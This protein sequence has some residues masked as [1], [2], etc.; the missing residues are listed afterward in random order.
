M[1]SSIGGFLL[2]ITGGTYYCFMFVP[3][4]HDTAVHY[5]TLFYSPSRHV[6][7]FLP[8]LVVHGVICETLCNWPKN[9]F[10]QCR[11]CLSAERG[12]GVD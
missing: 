2:S 5:H 1:T 10:C 12:G 3:Q 8:R 6:F 9:G 11:E 4:G 7:S